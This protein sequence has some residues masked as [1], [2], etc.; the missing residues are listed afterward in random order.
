[1]AEL[2]RTFTDA[3]AAL[4]DRHLG[5]LLFAPYAADLAARVARL[6]GSR[7]LETAAG[8]GIVTR[9]LAAALPKGVEI[10]ATDL[11]EPMLAYAAKAT[12]A[13]IDWRPADAAALP[14]ADGS[15]DIVVCQFGVMFFPDK[16]R[17]FREAWRVLRPGGTFL[18]NVW[19]R[20]EANEA[21]HLVAETVVNL[22]PHDPPRFLARTP[23]GY[24]DVVPL[25]AELERAG[26]RDI[27][28]ETV[29]RRGRASSYRDPAIG[30]C[31]GTP[32]RSEIEARDP[33]RR[34]EVV[35]KVAAAVRA[36]FGE[37]PFETA[38]SAH[39]FAGTR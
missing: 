8:T 28:V 35:E 7:I 30:L 24:H 10:V 3:I 39:V 17:G 37:G 21:A 4:Y 6:G 15:F 11:N 25:K 27:S 12:N 9:A 36:R 34:D 5:P 19:D 38:L 22:F 13:A 23:H 32:M 33:A 31:L 29:V 20:I 2:D 16:L 14:F 26:F 18:F 1:M